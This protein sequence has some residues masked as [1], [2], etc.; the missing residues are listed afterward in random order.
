[1]LFALCLIPILYLFL[2][3]KGIY[4]IN[5]E[6]YNLYSRFSVLTG[7]KN[8]PPMVTMPSTSPAFSLNSSRILSSRSAISNALLFNSNPS[9]CHVRFFET[10]L[11]QVLLP[12]LPAVWI[13]PA[14]LSLRHPDTHLCQ[15]AVSPCIIWNHGNSYFFSYR[16]FIGIQCIC[17]FSSVSLRLYRNNSG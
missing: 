13:M 17:G 1:M 4:L 16:L 12:G 15:S 5:K 14:L 9:F 8:C 11:F 3:L 7:S 10:A 2:C 6:T